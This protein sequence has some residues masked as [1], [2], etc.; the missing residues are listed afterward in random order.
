MI[1]VQHAESMVATCG[2]PVCRRDIPRDRRLTGP[3]AGIER[4]FHAAPAFVQHV[5][6]NHCRADVL[7]SVPH[8]VEQA[9]PGGRCRWLA[10]IHSPSSVSKRVF[11]VP[12]RANA[13]IGLRDD[14]GKRRM[15]LRKPR[16]LSTNLRKLSDSTLWVQSQETGSFRFSLS[17]SPLRLRL[18]RRYRHITPFSALDLF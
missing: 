9:G 10:G 13:L 3:A 16:I 18:W 17:L 1:A 4:A 11:L 5:G 15:A 6:V 8:L 2:N 12:V 7:I 14:K